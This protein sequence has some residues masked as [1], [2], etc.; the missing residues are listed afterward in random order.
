MVT[1]VSV[2]LVA[3]LMGRAALGWGQ[4]VSGV[5]ASGAGRPC[6]TIAPDAMDGVTASPE[7]HAVLYEDADVRVIEVHS[8]PHTR[9]AVHTHAR[10][11]VMYIDRQGAGTYS[12][13]D[14]SRNTSHPTDPNFKPR[15]IATKPSEG[16]H[17][18]ENTGEVP[19]HAIRVEFKHPGC[20]VGG[21]TAAS[22]GADD[23]LTAA[24]GSHASLIENADVRVLDVHLAPHAKEVFHTH[25]WPGVVYVAQGAAVRYA[26]KGGEGMAGPQFSAGERVVRV[27]A[28]GYSVENLG[29]TPLHLVWFEL[30]YGGGPHL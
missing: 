7:N 3:V 6:R 27:G 5:V 20:G 2:V 10:P 29:E 13:P 15:I 24:P 25:P 21:W 18:T 1:R 17:W 12:T 11:A 4:G 28:G 9:E 14:G 8:Q 22:P 26:G 30:K 16:P 19:Y 23:A